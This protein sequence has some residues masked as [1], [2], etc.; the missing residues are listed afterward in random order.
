MSQTQSE[1]GPIRKQ[2]PM[3]LWVKVMG[4]IIL[5]VVV[6]FGIT[7]LAGVQHG[8]NLHN[9]PAEHETQHP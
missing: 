2:P 7:T 8:P 9:Q 5:L 6:L 1:G 3:P 4:I